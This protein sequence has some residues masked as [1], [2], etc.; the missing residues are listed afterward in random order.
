MGWGGHTSRKSYQ[1]VPR[2]P[3]HTQLKSTPETFRCEG[4]GDGSLRWREIL[5]TIKTKIKRNCVRTQA[6]R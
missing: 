5:P 4:T 3:P 1:T 2:L 6:C